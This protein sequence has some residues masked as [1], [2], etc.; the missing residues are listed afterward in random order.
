MYLI[1][2]FF[3]NLKQNFLISRRD[4]FF[5]NLKKAIL[6]FTNPSLVF[7]YLSKSDARIFPIRGFPQQFFPEVTNVNH[8]TQKKPFTF[9]PV[10]ISDYVWDVTTSI[11]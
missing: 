9:S 6:L 10:W 11:Q 4:D 5:R 8:F 2:V 1:V 3:L 7:P